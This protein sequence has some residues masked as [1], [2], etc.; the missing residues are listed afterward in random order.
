MSGLNGLSSLVNFHGGGQ[1]VDTAEVDTALR[2]NL[3]RYRNYY[4]DGDRELTRY[5]RKLRAEGKTYREIAEITNTTV[6]VVT[7][8]CSDVK[9]P[10][11]GVTGPKRKSEIPFSYDELYQHLKNPGCTFRT[12]AK[13]KGLT[14]NTITYYVSREFGTNSAKLFMEKW[15]DR[16]SI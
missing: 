12:F 14:L 10:R 4:N 16:D 3:L 13:R 7:Y 2:P 8:R 15:E 5:M 9:G 11:A 6:G 1:S